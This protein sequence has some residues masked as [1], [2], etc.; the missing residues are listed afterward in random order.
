MF[1]GS[2][3]GIAVWHGIGTRVGVSGWQ[4]LL[5]KSRGSKIAMVLVRI[6]PL[7]NNPGSQATLTAAYI[8]HQPRN[9][10]IVFHYNNDAERR[11]YR[12][13]IHSN[14]PDAGEVLGLR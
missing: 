5:R 8:R 2:R 4:N 11:S 1:A 3:A 12:E 10:S 9:L 7:V 14:E 6:S 13:D